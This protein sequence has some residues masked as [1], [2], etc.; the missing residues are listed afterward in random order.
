MSKFDAQGVLEQQGYT[1][2]AIFEASKHGFTQAYEASEANGFNPDSAIQEGSKE[3]V[4]ALYDVLAAQYGQVDLKALGTFGILAAF[5]LAQQLGEVLQGLE[6]FAN[7]KPDD[8]DVDKKGKAPTV[9][10]LGGNYEG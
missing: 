2:G 4:L 10:V 9:A 1:L 6:S 5:G 7:G 8:F 3:R